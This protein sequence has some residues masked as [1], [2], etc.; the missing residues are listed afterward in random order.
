[1]SQHFRLR[2][3]DDGGGPARGVLPSPGSHDSMKVITL[4]H[5]A[6]F[7]KHATVSGI[8]FFLVLTCSNRIFSKRRLVVHGGFGRGS[9]SLQHVSPRARVLLCCSFESDC[10]GAG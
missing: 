1:M 7:E 3:G 9:Y 6:G 2:R 5:A 10:E 4:W 8:I